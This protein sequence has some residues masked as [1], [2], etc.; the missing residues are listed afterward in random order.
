M[1]KSMVDI[2]G[3][4]LARNVVLNFLSQVVPLVIGVVTI[5]FIVRGLGTER[6]GL[7]SLAWVILGYFTIFDL[8][9]GR[10]T[11]KYVA[12]ALGRGNEDQVPRLVW[13][14]V[15]VQTILGLIGALVLVGITRLLVERILNIPPE[16]TD[17]AKA[18]FYLLAP[19]IPIVLIS[20][21]FSGVLEAKQRF[22]LVNA[23][24]IPS[25][26]STYLLTLIGLLLGFQLP[27]IV[28]LVLV[29]RFGALSA[30][31]VFALRVFPKLTEFS[32]GFA[33]FPRLFI[34]GGWIMVSNIVGPIFVYLDR[35]LIASLLSMAAVGYYTAPYE[36]V[37]RL[38]I[39]PVSLTMTLFPAFSAL[40]GIGDGQRLETLFAR[41]IKYIILTLGTIVL[42]LV[43]F[44]K[45]LLQIWLGSDFA[46]QSVAVLQ[47]LALGVL[48][49]SLAHIPYALLQG[50]GRPDI[51]A[52]FHMLELPF[53]IGAIWLLV[54]NWGI[55]GAAAAWALRAA[56]D[57][58]LLFAAAFKVYGLSLRLLR[59][60][61]LTFAALAIVL[62]GVAIYGL[63]SLASNA[64]W[65]VQ[66]MLFTALLGFF[67]WIIWKYVLD[68]SDRRVIL[69]VVK[70]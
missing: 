5:P 49:N 60:N 67:V 50:V 29:A 36:A 24:R 41:S 64:P 33:L 52:K 15:T 51:T 19:A 14:A 21:S 47:I 7:L 6:F 8:G 30:L 40:G 17:E 61:G 22:D 3:H 31:V 25:G 12:E 48:V 26:I 45:E 39:I 54:K 66:L 13:T 44:A 58:L 23:V 35:F 42:I 56:L 20:G 55:S 69:K 1:Y 37:T 9:L 27:G 46:V 38:W 10:A 53:H 65:L 16:L 32:A 63:K 28:A 57:A 2:R 62:L 68:A 59:D 43:L 11:T 70:P 34:Y 18:T 4:L